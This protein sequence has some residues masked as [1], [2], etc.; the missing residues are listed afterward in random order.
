MKMLSIITTN[1][2]H[3]MCGL[4]LCIKILRNFRV[5]ITADWRRYVSLRWLQGIVCLCTPSIKRTKIQ[6]TTKR[7][8]KK[9]DKRR[10][11]HMK[12]KHNPNIDFCS[13]FQAIPL[14]IFSFVCL[15]SHGN[16]VSLSP[17]RENYI[18]ASNWYGQRTTRKSKKS[19][20]HMIRPNINNWI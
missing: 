5:R 8:R 4:R 2:S 16:D 17:V 19:S 7:R 18:I 10:Q 13:P 15:S 3:A 12:R 6:R 20:A 14:K 9:S 11:P 1:D